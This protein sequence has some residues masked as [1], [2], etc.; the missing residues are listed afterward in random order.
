MRWAKQFRLPDGRNLGWCERGDPHGQ[1][2]FVFHGLPGSR[3]Q[4]H[5]EEDIAARAGARVIS[6]DRPG[7]GLS[8]PWPARTLKDWPADVLMLADHL[9]IAR[10]AVAGISGGGPFA[11]ACACGLPGRVTRAA[12]L[13]SVGP[14]GSMSRSPSWVVRSGFA[15][16]RGMPLLLLPV[17]ALTAWVAVRSPG[18]YLSQMRSR[19][20]PNDRDILGRPAVRAVLERDLPESF[21]SGPRG[22]LRD[23]ELE[24]GAWDI[25]F[26]RVA[27]PV[28]LW[29]GGR[30]TIVPPAAAE[31]LA[32]LLP[33]AV[34]H[35]LPEAGHFFVFDVWG[36]IL[37]WLLGN[38]AA[39]ADWI[40]PHPAPA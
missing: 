14:P 1:A 25:D 6:V 2:V 17:M 37:G 16:A 26:D 8:D 20:S 7:F 38:D 30:D 15:L 36:E 23:L 40:V 28:S 27:C 13:A 22:F 32:A 34:V 19:L 9:C 5:P 39:A 18:Y 33:G 31:A 21:R 35:R 29:Q 24:A 12:M 3:L 4:M 11:C 10:F